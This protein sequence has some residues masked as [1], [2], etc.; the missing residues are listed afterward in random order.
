MRKT[1]Q[2]NSAPPKGRKKNAPSSRQRQSTDK[3]DTQ[4]KRRNHN[5]GNAPKE[6]SK[7]NPFQKGKQQWADHLTQKAKQENYPAR[8]V[9]KLMEIQK[10]HGVMKPGS[11]IV[12]FGC[13]PGSWLI[14][15]A[16]TIGDGGRAVGI[17][18][19][20]VETALPPNAEAH[21]GDI[22]EMHED[23]AQVVGKGYD[24]VLSDMAPATTGR[25]D[26]DAARSLALCE[27]A[28]QA[29]CNLLKPGGHFVCKI[30]QGSEFKQFETTVKS[31]FKHH[32]IFKPESCRKASK[33]I[34]I[35]GKGFLPEK[36]GNTQECND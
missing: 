21:V 28:L 31:R 29:A 24:A 12:D 10:K 11:A 7:G 32:A 16:R 36:G 26:V 20:K 6:K 17:D 27:A 5:S 34:Y 22:F 2:R 23:L 8:S 18:L 14:Y 13:A 33:E 4:Q 30:F 3:K 9:Y 35:I 25:K 1:S 19:K 15:A